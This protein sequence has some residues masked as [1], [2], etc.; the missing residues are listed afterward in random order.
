MGAVAGMQSSCFFVFWA[1]FFFKT[2]SSSCNYMTSTAY[3]DLQDEAPCGREDTIFVEGSIAVKDVTQCL[4]ICRHVACCE[5]FTYNTLSKTCGIRNYRPGGQIDI[6]DTKIGTSHGILT[7]CTNKVLVGK[8]VRI[9]GGNTGDCDCS[10]QIDRRCKSWTWR[11][12]D[13]LCIHNYGDTRRQ[14]KVPPISKI[15]SGLK[16]TRCIGQKPLNPFPSN[17]FFPFKG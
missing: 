8:T 11:R 14:L 10:C 9:R 4:N 13:E 12:T 17:P 5:F 7:G 2:V 6:Q 15:V 16:C 1:C 3:A